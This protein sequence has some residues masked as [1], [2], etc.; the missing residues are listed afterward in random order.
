MTMDNHGLQKQKS[1]L[2]AKIRAALEKFPPERRAADSTKACALLRQKPV[3]QSAQSVLLFA[4]QADELHVWPLLDAGIAAGKIAALPAF[5]I[6][7]QNYT[8]RRVRRPHGNEIV[9]GHFGI[10]EPSKSCVEIPLDHF[11]LILVPG[12]A[13]DLRGHRLGRG[14]GFYDRLLAEV[15]GVKCGIAFDGQI[16]EK[17][18]AEAHDV[19]MDFILTPTRCLEI[20]G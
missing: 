15:R 17:I 3:W 20:A 14:K 4:S 16:V 10:R 12:I 7:S 8:A 18:P 6:G 19:R 1:E 13:F 5:D 2:R 9:S 11:D